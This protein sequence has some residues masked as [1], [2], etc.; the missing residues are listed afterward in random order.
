MVGQI[1]SKVI[2]EEA[3]ASVYGRYPHIHQ[4]LFWILN[5]LTDKGSCPQ[6]AYDNRGSVL[7]RFMMTDSPIADEISIIADEALGK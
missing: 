4:K 6:V 1:D 3:M 7:S 2:D 5:H